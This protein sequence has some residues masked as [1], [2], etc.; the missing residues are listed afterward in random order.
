LDSRSLQ[1]ATAAFD[2]ETLDHLLSFGCVKASNM[3]ASSLIRKPFRRLAP[4]QA[5]SL[6]SAKGPSRTP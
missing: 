2:N 6:V 3:E 5:H 1:P 4:V